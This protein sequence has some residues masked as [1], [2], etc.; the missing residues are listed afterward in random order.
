MTDGQKLYE[1]DGSRE[2]PWWTLPPST[3]KYWQRKAELEKAP[4][5]FAVEGDES[6]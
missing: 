5:L 1:A 2:G 6:K 3:Q 4:P